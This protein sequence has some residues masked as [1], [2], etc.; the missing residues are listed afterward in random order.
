MSVF[1]LTPRMKLLVG[2][3][4]CGSF[5]TFSTFSVDVVQ[6]I[7]RGEILKATSY[8]MANNFGGIAAAAAGMM[9]AKKIYRL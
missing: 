8:A 5:T 7:G 4:F 2:A 1:G 3:G 9:I 6:M